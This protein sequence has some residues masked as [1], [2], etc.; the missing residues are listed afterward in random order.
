MRSQRYRLLFYAT[1]ARREPVADW[2]D[3]LRVEQ[4]AKVLW[5]LE[6]LA[7]SGFALGPPWLRKLDEEIW[8][9]RITSG[10][11]AFRVLFAQVAS[12]ELLLLEAFAK[13]TEKTP[14][15]YLDTAR[16]RLLSHWQR[17]GQ[18]R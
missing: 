5:V 7:D 1:A 2:L 6:R 12:S 8:E 16:K 18:G 17:S 4:R 13:K 10:K 15:R 3:R 14:S 9:V 11:S